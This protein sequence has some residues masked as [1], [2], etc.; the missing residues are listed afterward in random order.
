MR[1]C[2]P[3]PFSP[4]RYSH[5]FHGPGL[6]Y[7]IGIGIETGYIVWAHG[8]FPSGK[9]SDAR[10]FKLV[11]KTRLLPH[12]NVVADGGYTDERCRKTGSTSQLAEFFLSFVQGTKMQ[13]AG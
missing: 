3:T 10:I 6:R 7:E 13:T 12:E 5:K 1:I 8:P 9:Y 2:E 11:L 4:K